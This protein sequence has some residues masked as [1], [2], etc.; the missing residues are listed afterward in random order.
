MAAP[1]IVPFNFQPPSAPTIRT[2]N[3]TIPSGKYARI[4]D[5]Y[6]DT[7]FNTVANSYDIALFNQTSTQNTL[8]NFVY[9]NP[10]GCSYY[11]F[12]ITFNAA[13]ANIVN[14]STAVDQATGQP[15][16][17]LR[18]LRSGSGGGTTTHSSIA[19]LSPLLC[20]Q[21]STN[22][23]T[24]ITVITRLWIGSKG[25]M[26]VPSGTVISGTTY[27]VQEYNMIS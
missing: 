5:L 12:T 8:Q 18:T 6:G 20:V 11:T 13:G 4:V 23:G 26:W 1:F 25:D 21:T 22:I 7:T 27:Q 10:V 2:T 3:Y 16:S 24:T 19:Y 15:S 9:A 17:Q 14:I